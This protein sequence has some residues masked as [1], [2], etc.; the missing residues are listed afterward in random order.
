[1]IENVGEGIIIILC[2]AILVILIRKNRPL[3]KLENS[4]IKKKLELSEKILDQQLNTPPA[5]VMEYL[6]Q[7][8][9]QQ[10]ADSLQAEGGEGGSQP[11][12]YARKQS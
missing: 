3:R 9:Q 2:V 4:V 1:M 12:G 7:Q 6:E 11:I 5:G 10:Q 8:Q